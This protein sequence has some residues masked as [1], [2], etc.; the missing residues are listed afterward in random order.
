MAEISITFQEKNCDEVA[1]SG[2][3]N[4]YKYEGRFL[5]ELHKL[6]RD[7][8]LTAEYISQLPTGSLTYVNSNSIC[9]TSWHD[10]VI[11]S[12]G[13]NLM[14]LKILHGTTFCDYIPLY[15]E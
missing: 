6:L 7:F 4:W 15:Y 8:D 10:H 2:D 11:K 1:M 14:N 3:L 12:E 13:V 5:V 9:S